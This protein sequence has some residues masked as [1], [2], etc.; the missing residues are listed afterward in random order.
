MEMLHKNY[1]IKAQDMLEIE[2][3]KIKRVEEDRHKEILSKIPEY[4]RLEIELAQ[5]M[6]EVVAV[7]IDKSEKRAEK[8]NEI[9]NRNL[10]LQAKMAKTLEKHGYDADYLKP[11]Y[12][13]PVCQDKGAVNGEWCECIKRAAIKFA[14]DDFNANGAL[15]TFEDFDLSLYSDEKDLQFGRSPR[16][17]MK[18]NLDDCVKYVENFNGRG[19]GL[20]MMGATGLGKTHLSLSIASE[21]LKKGYSVVYRSVPEFVRVLNS[22]QFGK[23]DN[24]TIQLVS[25]CDLLILDDLGAEHSTDYS[26]SLVYQ[27]LNARF[28]VNK[29]IIASTNLDGNEIKARY[30]DR[31]WSRLFSMRVLLF[32]GTDNRLSIANKNW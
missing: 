30:Q 26:E 27:L 24:N 3:L 5:T 29:P 12:Y 7:F 23:T 25:D 16:E 19:G 20:F 11:L 18:N 8:L 4:E 14:A 28:S 10:D 2:R 13:C 31:I 21:L 17:I 6:N 32:C 9:K 15:C 22:D 1:L